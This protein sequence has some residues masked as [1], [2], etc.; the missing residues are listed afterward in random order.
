MFLFS[1][2]IIPEDSKILD[3]DLGHVLWKLTILSDLGENLHAALDWEVTLLRCGAVPTKTP[4]Q[5]DFKNTQKSKLS[6]FGLRLNF[7]N[8]NSS[9]A[10]ASRK[11]IKRLNQRRKRKIRDLSTS[12][13]YL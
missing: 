13:I 6:K 10:P 7:E 9:F 5:Y 4:K 2:S 12:L 1:K 3:R 11:I 8:D